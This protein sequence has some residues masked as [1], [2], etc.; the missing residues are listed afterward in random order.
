MNKETLHH[1]IENILSRLIGEDNELIE[2]PIVPAYVQKNLRHQL[3]PYQQAALEHLLFMEGK[4]SSNHLLFL[5]ATGSGKTNVLAASIL[6]LY[7]QKGF[8]NFLFFVNSD[9]IIRKTKENLLN[10]NSNKYLFNPEGIEV[11]GERISVQVVDV[12]PKEKSKQTIYLK[13]TTIQKLHNEL[14]HPRENGLTYQSLAEEELIL[15]SDEAHHINVQTKKK[16]KKKETKEEVEEKNWEST[17]SNI[18]SANPKNRM[19]EFTAT[20]NLDN[21]QLF[22]KYKDKVLFQYDLPRFMNEEYSKNVLLAKHT[23]DDESK[24]LKA[25]LMNQYRKYVALENEI[26]LKPVIMYKS[27]TIT[28]SKRSQEV[29]TQMIQELSEP[30]LKK[31]V[32]RE[33]NTHRGT[34]TVWEEV[35]NYYDS[36][37]LFKVIRDL[38]NDFT[39]DTIL[40]VNSKEIF[41]EKDAVLLNSLE[42]MNN[43]IRAIFAVAKLNEGWDVLNLFD[44]VRLSEK[45]SNTQKA[46]DSEAQ[47]IGRGAR[48]YPF[49][50]NGKKSFKRRFDLLGKKLSVLESLHY[51]TINESAYIK[52]LIKSLDA[53]GIQTKEEKYT[54]YEAKLKKKFKDKPLYKNGKI[55]INRSV[56]TTPEDYN[57]FEKYAIDTR[58]SYTF[59]RTEEEQYGKRSQSN[60][61]LSNL[62]TEVQLP[63]EKRMIQKAIQRNPFFSF[64]VLKK[65][66]PSLEN[67][68]NFI[69][70][71]SFMGGCQIFVRIPRGM[72]IADLSKKEQLTFIDRY[73]LYI[74]EKMKLNFSKEKGT[75]EFIGE[76]FANYIEENYVIETNSVNTNNRTLNTQV[77]S[78][79]SMRGQDWYI[80][81]QAI[82]NPLEWALIEE[83]HQ[84]LES[85][86]E[87]Y[88]SIFLVRNE[89]RVKFREIE[90][91]RGFMPDFL[92]FMED[93]K[94]SYQLFIEPKGSHLIAQ[95]E[96][97]EKFMLSLTEREDIE[98]L[99]DGKEVRLI[100]FK[101]YSDKNVDKQA[102]REDFVKKLDITGP[103]QEEFKLDY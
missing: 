75:A 11:N 53:A 18:M 14:T 16:G 92:L 49:K 83:I 65:Y 17:V 55:Y 54:R 79:R 36:T 61:T 45:A 51:H 10:P 78:S 2:R 24:M 99:H 57:S 56:K 95:D 100:G 88:K 96:W 77:I 6:Y 98:V 60:S 28:L 39:Q 90:G 19:L 40:I 7:K 22:D 103:I 9:S 3:R 67:I 43:P 94:F 8:Q 71:P 5:M 81:D 26:D 68:R 70:S 1:Q 15:L 93:E 47:L 23:E 91:V 48:Y 50:Y 62:F 64:S 37:D 82:G 66:I 35:F 76:P 69:E 29:F 72:S 86:Q 32:Q 25:T 38:R 33:K 74:E 101:F 97:K 4:P 31:F 87:N 80:Y 44:I 20:L 13:L 63:L 102:F 85:L 42:D 52:N 27:N 30:K 21:D 58:V 84:F 73:L 41:S 59:E 12:F 34:S 89:R 46:T